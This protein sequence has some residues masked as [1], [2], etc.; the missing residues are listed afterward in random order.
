MN[1]D[2]KWMEIAISEAIVAENEGEVPV[3]AIIINNER[4]VAK[5]HNQPILKNDPTAH[6]EIQVLR[7]AG[8]KQKNYR[9]A[10][11]TLYVTLEPCLMCLGAMVHARIDRIIFGAFDSKDESCYSSID[12]LNEQ[13]PKNKIK[14]SGGVSENKCKELLDVF[15]KKKR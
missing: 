5:A 13:F 9:L 15:F 7:I 6:A 10:G 8:K 14:I 2:E 3:G 11:S 12:L 1:N 4:L